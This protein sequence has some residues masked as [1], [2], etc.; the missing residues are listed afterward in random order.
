MPSYPIIA[1]FV[2]RLDE[3]GLSLGVG[4]GSLFGNSETYGAFRLHTAP[5]CDDAIWQMTRSA[6]SVHFGR[7]ETANYDPICFVPAESNRESPIVQLDRE[8]ILIEG[9]MKVAREI[10]PSFVALAERLTS[11]GNNPI[12][13]MVG[14][15]AG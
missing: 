13:G 4:P 7:P 15:L 3:A 6:G 14:R 1:Q 9:R 10:A 11:D 2:A 8:A 5:M 12:A